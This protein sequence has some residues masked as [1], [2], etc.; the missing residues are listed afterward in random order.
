LHVKGK[1]VLV[2]MFRILFMIL[3]LYIVMMIKYRTFDP[4]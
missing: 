3:S 4:S 2:A 1:H